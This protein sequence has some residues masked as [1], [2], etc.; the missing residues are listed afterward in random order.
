MGQRRARRVPPANLHITLAF[1]GEV[2][3]AT[4]ACAE[5]AAAGIA[6]EAFE[7]HVDQLGYW[8]RRGLLWAGPSA[9][10]EPLARLASDLGAAL[11]PCGIPREQR[12]FQPHI[13]LARKAP[14]L[15]SHSP[16]APVVWPV[17]YFVLVASTLQAG[18]AT[19]TVVNEWP[20][21]PPT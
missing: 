8:R 20:L 15:P 4:R 5:A 17:R 7:L 14:R 2:A 10:P 13:T 9:A 6:G 19:Y 21:A 1:L 3:P 18:G 11:E 16:V 12:P